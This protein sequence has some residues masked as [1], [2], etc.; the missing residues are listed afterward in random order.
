MSPIE[1][2]F[3]SLT[4]G[5]LISGF[6]RYPR[7]LASAHAFAIAADEVASFVVQSTAGKL[8]GRSA[9]GLGKSRAADVRFAPSLS[10]RH[11]LLGYSPIGCRFSKVLPASDARTRVP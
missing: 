4:D 11:D 10:K 3:A 1:A 2:N 9:V 6:F 8:I 5:G 7:R